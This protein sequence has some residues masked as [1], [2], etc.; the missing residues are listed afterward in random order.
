MKD[1]RLDYSYRTSSTV[2]Y[3]HSQEQLKNNIR[4]LY[5][6]FGRYTHGARDRVAKEA[7]EV[8]MI[9]Y[10]GSDVL[11]GGANGAY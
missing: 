4:L 7:Y 3:Q 11:S 6:H 5:F 8:Y 2:E 10:L 9:R 1:E